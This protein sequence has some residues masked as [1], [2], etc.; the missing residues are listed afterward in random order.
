MVGTVCLELCSDNALSKQ[1][2]RGEA[3]RVDNSP[4][5]E[6]RRMSS[7]LLEPT[8][9]P[10]CSRKQIQDGV[11]RKVTILQAPYIP[12]NHRKL[13]CDRSQIKRQEEGNYESWEWKPQDDSCHFV[14]WDRDQ[15]CT[16]MRQQKILFLGDSL[17]QEASFSF[18]ELMGLRISVSR[19][20]LP[21][22]GYPKYNLAGACN[23]TVEANFHRADF[24]KPK[25]VAKELQE[26]FP[27]VAVLNR[28][29]HFESDSMLLQDMNETIGHIG[30]WQSRCTEAG[31]RCLLVWRT[32]VPGHPG[33]QNE[34]QPVTNRS[35]MEHLIDTDPRSIAYNWPLFRHQNKLI[36]DALS[37]SN[38]EFEMLD[39]YHLNV[40][41]PD[42]HRIA[43]DDCL[44]SCLNSNLD[45]YAQ[46]LLHILQRR[47]WGMGANESN[48]T[49]PAAPT[50]RD[51]MSV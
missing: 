2:H 44:H 50:P 45:V 33:C 36:E 31:K 39:A 35:A 51:M 3:V 34:T 1:L 27:D 15:F 47:G 9:R 7:A 10:L 25:I 18:G 46:I 48:E 41:R 32:T 38:I 19:N 17:S 28:G 22:G 12:P 14:R 21:R 8:A 42:G 43:F 11:W 30:A 49:E 23:G 13:L 4:S 20:G 24:I 40:L 29:A 6:A 37:N 26:R 5:I 16:L